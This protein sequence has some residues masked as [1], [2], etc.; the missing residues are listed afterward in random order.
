M[1]MILSCYIVSLLYLDY[2]MFDPESSQIRPGI[3]PESTRN[4]TTRVPKSS[5]TRQSSKIRTN[6]T[7]KSSQH[8]PNIIPISSPNRP[9]INQKSMPSASYLKLV[10][11]H[12]KYILDRFGVHFG[13]KMAPQKFLRCGRF[14]VSCGKCFFF[15]F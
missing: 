2:N 3:V 5:Q 12:L 11:G 14:A 7:P 8:H 6:I 13:S 10:F 4:H 1:L 15:C 9:K